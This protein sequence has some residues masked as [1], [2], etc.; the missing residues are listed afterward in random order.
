MGLT[1][2]IHYSPIAVSDLNEIADYITNTLF[3]PQAAKKLLVK[4][5]SSVENLATF[6]LIGKELTPYK[7][8]ELPYR[9]VK[10]DNYMVFYN[11][12]KQ[13]NTVYIMRVLYGASEYLT[14]L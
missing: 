8:E 14:E 2:N 11:V 4:I 3:S 9:W 13:E 1:Y 6:P 10:V 12:D 5:K 7:D